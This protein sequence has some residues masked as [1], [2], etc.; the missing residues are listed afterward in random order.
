LTREAAGRDRA[1]NQ[2]SETADRGNACERA[3]EGTDAGAQQLRLAAEAPHPLDA[4]SPALSMRFRL[5]SPLWPTS[6]ASTWPPPS[7]AR[8]MA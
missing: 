5:C 7:T 2:G 4:L 1:I 8:R 6:S 3:A